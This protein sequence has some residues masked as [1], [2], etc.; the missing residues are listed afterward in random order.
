MKKFV[1]LAVAI[2]LSLS[3]CLPAPVTD[4]PASSIDINATVDVFVQQTL[5]ALPSATTAPTNTLVVVTETIAIA[6]SVTPTVQAEIGVTS[7]GTLPTNTAITFTSTLTTTLPSTLTATFT[8]TPNANASATETL[9]ARF[10]GTLPPKVPYNSIELVNKSKTEAY[11]SLQV[12]LPDGSVTILEYPVGGL[13]AVQ[14]PVGRYKYVAWV[15]GNKITGSFVLDASTD[16][17]ITIFKDRIEVKK[18]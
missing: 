15:G 9:H 8:F 16:L 13:F 11:I 3:S 14:A 6:P 1:I 4:A 5:Q 18:R 17:R 12:T 2:G 10:Y 7:T